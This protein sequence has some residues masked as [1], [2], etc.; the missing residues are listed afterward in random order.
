MKI[1]VSIGEVF[2]KITIL[3]IKEQKIFQKSKLQ[4]IKKE[5]FTLK[6]AVQKEAIPNID[7]LVAELKNIN[8]R[9]WEAEDIIRECEQ[10]KEFKEEFIQCAR[11]DAYLNDQRFLIKKKINEACKSNIQEQKSY[12]EEVLKTKDPSLK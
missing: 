10:K 8:L 1:E 5:L 4:H 11:L 3:E 6:E 9:L 7:E 2:D 12:K